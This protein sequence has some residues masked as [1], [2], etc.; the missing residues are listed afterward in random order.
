MYLRTNIFVTTP[1][2]HDK[3]PSFN[4]NCQ[5]FCYLGSVPSPRKIQKRKE[6]FISVG[7]I[8]TYTLQNEN[9]NTLRINEYKLPYLQKY[10][11]LS[12]VNLWLTYVRVIPFKFFIIPNL[13]LQKQWKI[14]ISSMRMIISD[15]LETAYTWEIMTK[16]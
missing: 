8:P 1:L 3:K 15:S 9:I 14:K 6:S 2:I 11:H 10:L 4:Y 16:K 7:T 5:S 12:T 13:F